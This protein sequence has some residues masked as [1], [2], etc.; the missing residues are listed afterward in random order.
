MS[1]YDSVR[2]NDALRDR[3]AAEYVLGTLKG[4]ARRRFEG[5]LHQ[6]A[7][8]RRSVAEWQDRLTPLAE[9]APPTA[10]GPQVW[11]AIE[12]RLN[13]RRPVPAW[14]FWRSESVNF[15]RGLGAASSALA[16]VLA[17]VLVTRT[18]DA[19]RIDYVAT[20][21]DEQAHTVLLLTADSRHQA[22][23]V[24]LVANA[25]VASDKTLQLWAVPKAGHPR[26]LGL[27]ADRGEA[28][29]ALAAGAVDADVALLAV[30][31]EPKGG[32][33]D[34]NGPTGPILYK[35]SWLRVL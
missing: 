30:S 20:L 26:S 18:L 27:L 5:W 10:P 11:R 28:R 16:L 17:A 33:P 12:Q 35:G 3:L 32:S 15:W 1:I 19:P 2:R 24:K 21:S 6:D 7:A 23:N 34:P 4:G 9:F 14:Q 25:P 29:L 31:L 8:L 13:L 22:L